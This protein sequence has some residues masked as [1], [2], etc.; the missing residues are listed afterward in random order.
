MDCGVAKTIEAEV[1]ALQ[2]VPML[3]DIDPRRLKLLAFTA[4][5][6]VFV[7]G[8]KFFS[9][10]DPSSAAYVLLEGKADILIDGTS[11]PVPVAQLGQYQM[12]GEMGLLTNSPRSATVIASVQ[13]TV[14]R[15]DKDVFFELMR[16]FPQMALAVMVELAKRLEQSNERLVSYLAH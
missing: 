2:Q 5:R 12:V 9:Q 8:Q 6:I 14:L 10:G 4:E 7:P 3:K 16:H 11:G 13:T 1:Q 15:I